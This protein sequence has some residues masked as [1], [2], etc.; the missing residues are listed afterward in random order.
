L[1]SADVISSSSRS[2]RVEFLDTAIEEGAPFSR[3][4]AEQHSSPLF[5]CRMDKHNHATERDQTSARRAHESRPELLHD[6]R[7]SVIYILTRT[8]LFRQTYSKHHIRVELRPALLPPS[9][10][11]IIQSNADVGIC[12]SSRFLYKP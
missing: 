10:W 6:F 8:P 3:D 11:R 5:Q 2:K 1:T 4:D 7:V 12:A 9:F